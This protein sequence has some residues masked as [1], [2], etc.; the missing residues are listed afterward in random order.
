MALPSRKQHE[1]LSPLENPQNSFLLQEALS[2]LCPQFIAQSKEENST[3]EAKD[4]LITPDFLS[5][6]L[7]CSEQRAEMWITASDSSSSF[8]IAT[9]CLKPTSNSLLQRAGEKWCWLCHCF[10]HPFLMACLPLGCF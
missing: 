9:W 1:A 2:E 6:G 10:D 7:L 3:P 5:A 4:Q 8:L